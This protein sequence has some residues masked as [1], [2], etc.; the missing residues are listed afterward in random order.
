ML[1]Y[2]LHDLSS[3]IESPAPEEVATVPSC[4]P[5]PAL[6]NESAI[7]EVDDVPLMEVV[8]VC[9][10]IATSTKSRRVKQPRL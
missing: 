8:D 2:L 1:E 7:L 3:R 9:P 4:A 10:P 5:S 6:T